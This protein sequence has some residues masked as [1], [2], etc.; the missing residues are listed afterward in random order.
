MSGSQSSSNSSQ[1]SPQQLS[2]SSTTNQQSRYSSAFN[3]QMQH[4]SVPMQSSHYPSPNKKLKSMKRKLDV[5]LPGQDSS[6]S[7][8]SSNPRRINES[9][10]NTNYTSDSSGELYSWGSFKPT[11]TDAAMI[12]QS[13]SMLASSHSSSS[14]AFLE[15]FGN[16]TTPQSPSIRNLTS[17]QSPLIDLETIF[18]A[19][20]KYPFT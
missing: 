14:S 2:R 20:H 17:S 16:Q 13:P 18:Q 6:H 7:N 19:F 3:H 1:Y 8:L 12:F 4:P 11:M 10:S 9:I 5:M 15:P